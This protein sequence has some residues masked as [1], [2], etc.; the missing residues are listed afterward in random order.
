MESITAPPA[1][2]NAMQKVNDFGNTWGGAI[3]VLGALATALLLL[4]RVRA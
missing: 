2:K 1:L 4:K 3:A